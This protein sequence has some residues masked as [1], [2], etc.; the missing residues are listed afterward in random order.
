LRLVQFQ[1]GDQ[2]RLGVVDGD[3]VTDVK[4]AAA[5]QGRRDRAFDS[6]RDLLGAGDEAMEFVRSLRAGDSSPRLAD[7]KLTAPVSARKIVAVGLNYADHA[8]EA[9]MDLPT[10]P[11]CFAKFTSSLSGPYDPIPLTAED[12]QADYEAELG[13]VIGRQAKRVSEDEAMRYVAGYLAFNDV[14]AR[15]WQFGDSQWTRGKSCD[16]FAPNGPWL[17]TA[18]EIPDPGSLRIMTRVNG[19]TLQD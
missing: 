15:K 7:V 3:R 4:D 19:K 8:R 9:G 11:L 2:V 12:A 14:S 6:V 16:G 18:D 5:A 1:V 17:I 13:V 10:A